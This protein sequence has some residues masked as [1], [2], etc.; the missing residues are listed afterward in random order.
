MERRRRLLTRTGLTTTAC[1]APSRR[2]SAASRCSRPTPPSGSRPQRPSSSRRTPACWRRSIRAIG[3]ESDARIKKA[4]EEA[5]AAIM[6]GKPDAKEADRLAAIASPAR[7][8]RS[9]RAQRAGGRSPATSRP[10]SRRRSPTPSPRSTIALPSGTWR[11]T[12]GT[13]SRWVRCC[14]SPPSGSPS[15]SASWA[16][17]T[18]RTARW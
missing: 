17:S 1:A 15:P 4:L 6:V 9:G 5:R 13:G 8:R 16:S 12:S 7:S 2:P 11:R 3:K 14:C 18:W 10:T